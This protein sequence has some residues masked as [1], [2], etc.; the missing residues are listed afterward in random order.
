MRIGPIF[1][2]YLKSGTLK[3][4]IR[5]DDN[6]EMISYDSR[7]GKQVMDKVTVKFK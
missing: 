2:H 1:F 4:P 3:C 7:F 6:V 5:L